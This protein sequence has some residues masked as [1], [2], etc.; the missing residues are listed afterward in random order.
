MAITKST[1][2]RAPPPYSDAARYQ[3]AVALLKERI[4]PSAEDLLVFSHSPPEEDKELFT[5]DYLRSCLRLPLPPPPRP[6][7]RRPPKLRYRPVH[8]LKVHLSPH[9]YPRIQLV[10]RWVE[11]QAGFEL[12]TRVSVKVDK[13]RLVIEPAPVAQP[14]EPVVE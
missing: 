6:P 8:E 3:N 9:G 4:L 1:T 5:L 7:E 11:E 2:K 12:G 14:K 10:G 13:G